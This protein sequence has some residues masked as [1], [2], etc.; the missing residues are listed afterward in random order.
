M[1]QPATLSYLDKIKKNGDNPTEIYNYIFELNWKVNLQ[2]SQETSMTQSCQ[3]LFFEN[4]HKMIIG[5]II[6]QKAKTLRRLGTR[7]TRETQ[8]NR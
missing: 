6:R 3:F 2:E 8:N 5:N 4:Y 1:K 7:Q